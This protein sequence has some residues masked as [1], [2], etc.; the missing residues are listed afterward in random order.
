MPAAIHYLDSPIF[1]VWSEAHSI[2][3]VSDCVASNPLIGVLS[4]LSGHAF[5][6]H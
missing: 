5:Y 4:A 1:S 3:A 2:N 6:T